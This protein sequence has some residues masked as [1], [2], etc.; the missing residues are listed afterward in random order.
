MN[1]NHAA[2]NNPDDYDIRIV[3]KSRVVNP[4]CRHVGSTKRISQINPTW[5]AVVAAESQPKKYYLKYT[6]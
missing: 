5:D 2:T 6:Y 1:D 4:W 3:C